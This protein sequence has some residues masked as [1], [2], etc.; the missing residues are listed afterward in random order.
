MSKSSKTTTTKSQFLHNQKH[1][2]QIVFQMPQL[3]LT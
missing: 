3:N 2:K 1:E